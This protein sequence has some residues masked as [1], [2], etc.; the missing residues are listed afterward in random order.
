MHF[1][2]INLDYTIF[3]LL[4]LFTDFTLGVNEIK[5]TSGF[6]YFFHFFNFCG[7][8]GRFYGIAYRSKTSVT[9]NDVIFSTGPLHYLIDCSDHMDRKI[10]NAQSKPYYLTG[11][12]T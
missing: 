10:L 4:E 3:Y 7:R 2:L 5:V 11:D 1:I 12:N 8:C 6:K 9:V